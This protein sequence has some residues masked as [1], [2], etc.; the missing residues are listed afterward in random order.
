MTWN[1]VRKRD[2]YGMGF[3][4]KTNRSTLSYSA[5]HIL[6]VFPR[7]FVFND[8]ASDENV[9]ASVISACHFVKAI[10]DS[11]VEKATM[12]FMLTYA[13]CTNWVNFAAKK[14]TKKYRKSKI[15]K[16]DSSGKCQLLGFLHFVQFSFFFSVFLVCLG[17]YSGSARSSRADKRKNVM[18]DG[19]S[20]GISDTFEW[21]SKNVCAQKHHGSSTN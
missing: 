15:N 18:R 4:R 16:W 13:H 1:G 7:L 20:G 12:A 21:H 11:S 19:D 5:L 9:V 3:E 10:A 14:R 17:C 2:I 8:D 6:L